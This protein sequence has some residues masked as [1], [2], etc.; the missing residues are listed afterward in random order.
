MVGPVVCIADVAAEQGVSPQTISEFARAIGIKFK[1]YP[2]NKNGKGLDPSDVAA[3]KDRMRR[4]E[5]QPVP[6]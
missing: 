4:L 1:P 5:A 2:P 3:I 6:A